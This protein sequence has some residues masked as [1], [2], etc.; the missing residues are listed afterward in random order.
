MFEVKIFSM[1]K[2]GSK[3]GLCEERYIRIG[4]SMLKS[5][6]FLVGS[7]VIIDF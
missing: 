2:N 6:V 3:C 7:R 4:N 5:L 1:G